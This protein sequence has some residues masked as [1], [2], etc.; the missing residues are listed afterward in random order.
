MINPP[1][2]SYEWN[3]LFELIRLGSNDAEALS[4]MQQG[5]I[6]WIGGVAN[7]FVNNLLTT[8]D[9]RMQK[10]LRNF[11]Q[12]FNHV[13]TSEGLLISNIRNFKT[14]VR[15]LYKLV[16]LRCIP[17]TER[18]KYQKMVQDNADK[19]QENLENYFL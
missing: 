7:I 15:F 12:S 4:A 18:L 1:K 3:K 10:G 14:E 5:T 16:S 17:E 13:G 6:D 11:Q 2:T 8:V 19:I 9:Y